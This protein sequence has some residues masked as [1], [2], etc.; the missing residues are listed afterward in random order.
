M[1]DFLLKSAISLTIFLGFYHLV[2]ERE[3][4]HQFNR[5]YLLISILIS[6]I[7]PFV[8][9]EFIKI[10]PVIQNIEP[11]TIDAISKSPEKF[12]V[13][14]VQN[15]LQVEEAINYIP[16]VIWSFYILITL[17]LSVRFGKNYFRLVSKI[18]SNPTIKY[19]NA[20]LVLMEEKILPHTFLN[21]IFLNSEDYNNRNI[22]E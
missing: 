22:E 8:T 11:V 4:M 9:F 2:L 13:D 15:K 18:N 16:Y 7:L 6:L 1:I 12:V 5:F 17:M 19:K 21:S 14:T 10:I 20:N 3:K